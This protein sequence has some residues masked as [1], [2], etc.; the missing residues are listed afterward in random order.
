MNQKKQDIGVMNNFS[1]DLA[2]GFDEN[3]FELTTDTNNHVCK[4]G[5]IV[6][7]EGT[8]YGGIIDKIRVNTETKELVY[9]GRTWHGILETK[10]LEPNPGDDYLIVN[11]EA[12]GVISTLITRMGLDDLFRASSELSNLVLNNYKMNRYIKGYSGIKKMLSSIGGKLQIAFKDGYVELSAKPLID[13]SH[14]DEFDST[15]VKFDVEKVY[16]P[17]NH[18]IC[19][20]KGDLAERVVI[21]LYADEMGN[22]SHV[23]TAFG[24]D[25]VTDIYEYANAESDEELEEGGRNLLEEAWN[26]DS[27]QIDFDATKDYDIGDI[28]GA[29]ENVTG[30]FIAKPISKKIVSIKN[31]EITISHKVGE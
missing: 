30:I 20:G 6:Y 11:G 9:S 18:V 16:K 7:M 21:N 8:E 17:T 28:I 5:F 19:L 14:D 12:N 10:V 25:E 26:Q 29:R 3:D 31:N 15:Q 2:F 22:I 27:L 23:Q 4:D 13:Y 1:F 24:L